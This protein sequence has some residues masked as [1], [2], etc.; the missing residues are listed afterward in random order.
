MPTGNQR[1]K[2]P[3]LF[4]RGDYLVRNWTAVFGVTRE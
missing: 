1:R 4:W 2:N 3:A